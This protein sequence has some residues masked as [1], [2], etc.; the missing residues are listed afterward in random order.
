MRFKVPKGSDEFEED[1][2]GPAGIGD[3]VKRDL[4]LL[5]DFFIIPIG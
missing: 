5:Q 4:G 2:K 1:F 3:F